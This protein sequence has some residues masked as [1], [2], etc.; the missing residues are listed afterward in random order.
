MFLY[1]KIMVA[2]MFVAFFFG[3]GKDINLG[4]LANLGI[5]LSVAGITAF[6][7]VKT[8]RKT[9]ELKSTEQ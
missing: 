6:L 8:G 5:S 7:L 9:K 2:V 1:E 3:L 4:F